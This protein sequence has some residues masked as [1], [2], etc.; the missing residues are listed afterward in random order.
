[1]GEAGA[2][3]KLKNGL[4]TIAAL[5]ASPALA[6][7]LCP[8]ATSQPQAD[9]RMFNHLPYAETNGAIMQPAPPSISPDG[10][11]KVHPAIVAD[12]MR[13]AADADRD[14]MIAGQLR[15]LSCWRGT[16]YQRMVFCNGIHIGLMQRAQTSAP[17]GYSEHATG[18]V[19]DFGTANPGDCPNIEGC[20][21]ASPVGQWLLKNAPR[22]G[23]ELSFPAGSKQRVTWEPWHW[24]WVGTSGGVPGAASARA[25]FARARAEYP[26][27]P[28]PQ[29]APLVIRVM[30][31]PENP[32]AGK[33]P[34]A[35]EEKRK[36]RR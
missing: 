6:Q 22:Y 24:R 10:S 9:G 35:P 18:Y 26:A 12:L 32:N 7:Q 33:P 17:P 28:S 2:M 8:T 23:F 36:R 1:M 19:I 14:P 31:Q 21:A 34:P 3:G 11:C 20:F 4:M 15:A 13:M 25:V 5:A 16:E 30:S 27:S 29:E